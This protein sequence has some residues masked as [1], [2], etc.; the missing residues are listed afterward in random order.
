M[1]SNFILLL[2]LLSSLTA[3]VSAVPEQELLS[4]LAVLRARGYNLFANAIT[5]SDLQYEILTGASYTFFAPTDSTLFAFDMTATASDYVAG[6][7]SHA[8]SRRLSLAD[9]LGLPPD[10]SSL[11]T[12]MP[13]H[14]I[15]VER[16]PDVI[17]V[18]G[19][20]IVVPGM[21]YGRN[22]AV[23]GLGGALTTSR[24]PPPHPQA[25][26]GANVTSNHTSG[27]SPPDE[28]QAPP[29]PA[30]LT[31][32]GGLGPVSDGIGNGTVVSPPVPQPASVNGF[33]PSISP[34]TGGISYNPWQV[35]PISPVFAPQ[36]EA[37]TVSEASPSIGADG[38]SEVK[39]VELASRDGKEVFS[40]GG[41]RGMEPDQKTA[42]CGDSAG[43]LPE[44]DDTSAEKSGECPLKNDQ[45]GFDHVSFR[46]D[47]L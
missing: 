22:V 20:V 14:T 42:V 24:A 13:N 38:G 26:P 2:I 18:D 41:G 37:P 35:L 36:T 21:F 34:A 7:R 43:K 8:V 5:T 4:M 19:V 1:A 17:T 12:L 16:R 33:S 9:L 10:S 23:H 30:N 15:R 45:I 27:V 31:E 11:P 39:P 32:G 6:L 29:P 40:Y 25:D 46:D 44:V 28:L 3:A 47:F